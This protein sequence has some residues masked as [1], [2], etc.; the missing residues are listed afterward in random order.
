MNERI[1]ALIDDCIQ[2]QN[3]LNLLTP[4]V[5]HLD[6]SWNPNRTATDKQTLCHIQFVVHLETQPE[7]GNILKNRT[8]L[9]AA[10]AVIPCLPKQFR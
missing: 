1:A 6:P 5:L 10:S 7:S 9:R 4:I 2:L 8:S 3:E